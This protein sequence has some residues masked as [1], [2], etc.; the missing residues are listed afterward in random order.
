MSRLGADTPAGKIVNMLSDEELIEKYLQ[1]G[2]R[3]TGI[4]APV[5]AVVQ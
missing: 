4:F 5:E 3:P 1:H 2:H